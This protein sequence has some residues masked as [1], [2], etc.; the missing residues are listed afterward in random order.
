MAKEWYLTSSSNYFSGYENDEFSQ[1]ATAAFDEL[2][3]NS[4]ETYSVLVNNTDTKLVIIQYK[5]ENERHLIARIGEIQLGDIVNHKNLNWLVT[6]NP[7]DNKMNL[8]TIIK[9]CNSTYPIKSNKT[10]VLIGTTDLGK[11]IYQDT[12]GIDTTSPCIV[13]TGI[14][15]A[16]TNAQ[17]VIPNKSV[18]ITMKNQVSDT[19][20]VNY[21]FSMYSNQY[22]II[23]ID[24]TKVIADKGI[25]KILA[26][27]L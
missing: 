13:E 21:E 22:K 7:D 14:G 6:S 27:R 8:S 3:N 18:I 10:R 15:S 19:L 23:D 11:P 16:N 26:E 17:L 9:L 5:D 1:N 24:Y 2:L 25:I 12:W 20:V 4:P